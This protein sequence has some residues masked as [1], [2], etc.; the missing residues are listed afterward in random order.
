MTADRGVQKTTSIYSLQFV[1]YVYTF[2]AELSVVNIHINLSDT[3]SVHACMTIIDR[4]NAIHKW[5]RVNVVSNDWLIGPI[6]G[7]GE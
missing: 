7:I 3:P 2:V 6:I 4:K 5:V 1:K